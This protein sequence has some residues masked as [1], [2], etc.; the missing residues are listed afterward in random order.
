MET[1]LW[2]LNLHT[3]FVCGHQ[4]RLLVYQQYPS[5]SMKGV[6]CLCKFRLATQAKSVLACAFYLFLLIGEKWVLKKPTY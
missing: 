2:T 4:K 3:T 6:R 5:D 1:S